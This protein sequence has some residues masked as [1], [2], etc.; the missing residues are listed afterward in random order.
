MSDSDV[1][2][3][4][5]SKVVTIG[6]TTF[7]FVS[8]EATSAAYTSAISESGATFSGETGPAA[9]M[10]KILENGA[11]IAF[12][13][14]NGKIWKGDGYPLVGKTQQCIFSPY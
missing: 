2:I 9:P 13:S 11:V 4:W 14:Y 12:V 8:Y 3:Q 6:K 10:C 1:P 5:P 7:P